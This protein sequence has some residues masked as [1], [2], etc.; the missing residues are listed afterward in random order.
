MKCR[1]IPWIAGGGKKVP[2]VAG[3]YPKEL[4]L[5]QAMRGSFSWTE[6]FLEFIIKTYC[7]W[8]GFGVRFVWDFQCF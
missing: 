1:E 2:Y 5:K 8:V 4:I 6:E 3:L 7:T